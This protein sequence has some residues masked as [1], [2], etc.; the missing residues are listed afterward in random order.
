MTSATRDAI[1]NGALRIAFR[2]VRMAELHEK[3]HVLTLDTDFS[4]YRRHG[5]QP[6]DLIIPPR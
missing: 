4:V 2:V 5:R 1:A 3:H 6:L